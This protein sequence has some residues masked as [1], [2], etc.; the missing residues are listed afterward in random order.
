MTC[1]FLFL[2]HSTTKTIQYIGINWKRVCKMSDSWNVSFVMF[3]LESISRSW[4]IIKSISPIRFLTPI[5]VNSNSN[6]PGSYIN[7]DFVTSSTRVAISQWI[8]YVSNGVKFSFLADKFT[9]RIPFFVTQTMPHDWRAY[10][11]RTDWAPGASAWPSCRRRQTYSTF[12]LSA[13]IWRHC[14]KR[15]FHPVCYLLHT[16]VFLSC[17]NCWPCNTNALLVWMLSFDHFLVPYWIVQNA[18]PVP[19]H[20]HHDNNQS[21]TFDCNSGSPMYNFCC[22]AFLQST[23]TWRL[24]QQV[25]SP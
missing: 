20:H 14:Q 22:V 6:S 7:R 4:S 17:C 18:A 11:G 13:D 15:R 16:G 25:A 24:R 9:T 21:S 23:A 5:G 8:L 1:R 19:D 2:S 3:I 12:A 10:K